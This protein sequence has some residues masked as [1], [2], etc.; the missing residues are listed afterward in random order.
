MLGITAYYSFSYTVSQSV[1]EEARTHWSSI[2]L[3]GIAYM[4]S[5]LWMAISIF[6]H[7]CALEN[8]V[9]KKNKQLK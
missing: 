8:T 9:L 5:A 6:S 4:Y 3:K 1:W 2:D 7:I